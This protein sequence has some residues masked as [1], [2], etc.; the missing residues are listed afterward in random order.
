[1]QPSPNEWNLARLV[2]QACQN[3]IL[4]RVVINHG[5]SQS[6][7]SPG[8]LDGQ[9]QTCQLQVMFG[10]LEISE[11]QCQRATPKSVTTGRAAKRIAEPTA[12]HPVINM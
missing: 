5:Q 7:Q 2:P 9:L 6:V 8:Q 3:H 12:L 1:M 11:W 4:T 10:R